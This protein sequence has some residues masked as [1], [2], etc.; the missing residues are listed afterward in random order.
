MAKLAKTELLIVDAYNVIGNWEHLNR[1]KLDNKLPEA[2][3]EL[4]SELVEYQKYSGKEII[5]VFD[6]MY[7]PGLAKSKQ[8][9]NIK[10]VWT[11]KNETADTYIEALTARE[12]SL[13]MQVEVATSD[14]AEQW[15]IFSAGALRV[16]AQEL[17]VSVRRAKKEICNEAKNYNSNLTGNR[18]TFNEGQLDKLTQL[19]DKLS[20]DE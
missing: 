3:D 11:N 8:V 15:T 20:K 12:Q 1:L 2:R 18:V 14:H 16:S 10:V 6:A 9:N 7:V 13:F 4:I 17:L 19:R 5:V